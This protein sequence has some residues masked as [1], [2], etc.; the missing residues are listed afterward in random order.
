MV[1]SASPAATGMTDSP[2][3]L[4]RPEDVPRLR[5]GRQRR[6]SE[7]IVQQMI[8]TYPNR[9]VWAPDTLEF[10]LVA[11]WRHRSDVAV[12][13]ELAAV[14]HARALLAAAVENCRQAGDAIVLMLEMDERRHPSFYARAGMH[15]IEDV[16]T[17]DLPRVRP[18]SLPSAMTFAAADPA[19]PWQLDALLRIDHAAFPWLWWNSE[20]EFR[21][22]A[23]APGTHLYLGTVDRRPVAYLGMSIFPGWGHLDRIAVDPTIQGHGLGRQALVFAINTM[24][25]AGARRIALSTQLGNERSQ[26]LYERFGFQRSPGFDYRLYGAPMRSSARGMTATNDTPAPGLDPGAAEDD[27]HGWAVVSGRFSS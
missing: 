22:Y 12:I 18:V 15:P 16:I 13:D 14:K 27:R 4:L 26:R 25:R 10:V 11:P 23:A 3:R 24:H 5:L 8:A 7:A 20:E 9:S 2:I 19:E 21:V 1:Q 6:T 17:Y